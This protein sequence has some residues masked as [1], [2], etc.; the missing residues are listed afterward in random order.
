[1]QKLLI[2]TTNAGKVREFESLFRNLPI[3]LV[4]LKS[5]GK[6]TEVAETGTTFA[7][8]ALLKAQGYAAQ[9]RLMTLAED[10]GLCCDALDGAPGVYSARFAGE[11]KGDDDNNAKLLGIFENIPVNCRGAQYESHIAIVSPL[12]QLIGA[13]SG[14]VRGVIHSALIGDQGFGYDPLFFYPPFQKTFGQI[15]LEEKNKVSHRSRAMEK[16]VKILKDYLVPAPGK[17]N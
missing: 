16:A 11:G 3:E 5:L 9:F 15:S 13:C 6:W 8:N 10:S 1:M 4:S 7:Q 17:S 2:A 14:F 12:G